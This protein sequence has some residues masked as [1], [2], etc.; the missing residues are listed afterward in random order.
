M[1]NWWL[2]KLKGVIMVFNKFAR[3]KKTKSTEEVS[4]EEEKKDD[5]EPRVNNNLSND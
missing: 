4:A 2:S 5:E 1:A 3:P